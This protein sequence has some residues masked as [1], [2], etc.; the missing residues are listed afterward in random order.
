MTTYNVGDVVDGCPN[1]ECEGSVIFNGGTDA[2]CNQCGATFTVSFDKGEQASDETPPPPPPQEPE[3]R[4]VSAP[5][6]ESEQEI[7]QPTVA[8]DITEIATPPVEQPQETTIPD[9]PIPGP[10][11]VVVDG[12]DGETVG[13]LT[14]PIMG[15]HKALKENLKLDPNHVES[16]S[17]ADIGLPGHLMKTRP[18][19]WAQVLSKTGNP[20][21]KDSKSWKIFNI[22]V[23]GATT[24]EEAVVQAHNIGLSDKLS[25]L[26]TVYEVM[27][28]CIVAGLLVIDPETRIVSTCQSTPQ[29]TPVP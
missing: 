5:E 18:W 7:A 17:G 13:K 6:P 19:K 14:D 12:V 21:R 22:F 15:S 9:A 25:Y 4:P 1:N 29:P 10:V 2:A 16:G 11:D 27:N 3:A 28:H 24:P 8:D 20:Y 26:L 23:Q